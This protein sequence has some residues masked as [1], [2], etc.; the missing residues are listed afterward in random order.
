M[1]VKK[2]TPKKL[3]K[4]VHFN[5]YQSIKSISK[6]GSDDLESISINMALRAN[7]YNKVEIKLSSDREVYQLHF[8][9]ENKEAYNDLLFS[10]TTMEAELQKFK[11]HL[12]NE[13][14]LAQK[15]INK[16]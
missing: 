8:Y 15:S 6:I 14:I 5:P 1:P 16:S 13:F 2:V 3:F 10:L 9:L 7:R 4:N 11:N 12:L